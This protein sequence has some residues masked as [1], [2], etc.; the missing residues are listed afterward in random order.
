VD[1]LGEERAHRGPEVS[2]YLGSVRQAADQ[3]PAQPG[4]YPADDQN[5]DG[6]QGP[7]TDLAGQLEDVDWHGRSS[8]GAQTTALCSD[9]SGNYSALCLGVLTT[10][11]KS[12]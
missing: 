12:T 8:S 7:Q 11:S 2:G 3:P 10:V 9:A 4:E 6:D 1:G 5:R